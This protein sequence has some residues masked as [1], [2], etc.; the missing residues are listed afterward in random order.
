MRLA[1]REEKYL[2]SLHPLPDE[3]ELYRFECLPK[4]SAARR[5]T[6]VEVQGSIPRLLKTGP[7][8][9]KKTWRDRVEDRTF[10]LS[11]A[12]LEAWENQQTQAAAEVAQCAE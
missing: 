6:H 11:F 7:R 12:E 9:G 5:F 1:S 8:K 3:W 4:D 10:V 2:K